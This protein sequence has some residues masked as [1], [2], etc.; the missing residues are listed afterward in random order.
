MRTLLRIL[1]Q[2]YKYLIF[3]PILLGSTL[4]FGITAALLTFIST[5]KIASFIGGVLWSRLNSYATPMLVKVVGRERFD[6]KQ[7]YVIVSNHLSHYDV[8]VLYGWLGI[9]FKWVMKQELRRIPALGIGC[10]KIGHIFIDRSNSDA[11]LASINTA[12]KK[13]IN[14]TSVVFFPEGTRSQTGEIMEFKK[15]A[16]KFALDMGLPVLPVTLVNTGNILPPDTFNLFPGR[17]ILIFHDPIPT[18]GYSDES[19]QTLMD[20]TRAVM[21]SGLDTAV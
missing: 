4:V 12:K 14:G 21:Q 9:D 16:F 19:I 11:A 1:Y 13:I 5:P 15:G 20:K 17:A 3:V 18:A 10:E 8:F 2:P 6:P 7:S